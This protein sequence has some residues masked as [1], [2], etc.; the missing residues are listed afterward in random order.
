MPK[1]TSI[2]DEAIHFGQ[3]IRRLRLE[4]G[5]TIAQL[6]RESKYHPNHLSNLEKG[7]N[8][9]SLHSILLL[10]IVFDADPAEWVREIAQQFRARIQAGIAADEKVKRALEHP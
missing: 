7:S 4:R 5:W 6:A 8:M 2:H 3:I 10:S 1:A 9:P